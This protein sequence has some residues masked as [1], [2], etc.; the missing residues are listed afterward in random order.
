[1]NDRP[2]GKYH[3]LVCDGTACHF[4]HQDDLLLVLWKHL[5]LNHHKDTTDDGL[6]TV[7]TCRCLGVCGLG[8]AIMVNEQVIPA[9]TPK[10]LLD[11]LEHLRIS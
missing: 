1:M 6:F 9:M 2:K 5:G 7:E 8:N 3:I 10:K 11:L 4:N